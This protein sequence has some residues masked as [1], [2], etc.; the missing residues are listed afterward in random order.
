MG[1]WHTAHRLGAGLCGSLPV[2]MRQET[3]M[4][5]L[6]STLLRRAVQTDR[7][8]NQLKRQAVELVRAARDA[9]ATW[10]DVGVAFGVTRQSAHQRFSSYRRPIT[11]S[12]D[13]LTA[14]RDRFGSE[15]SRRVE[16]FRDC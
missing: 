7:R 16:G 3:T 4:T 6:A 5:P 10:A 12:V 8:A 9:G 2:V 1:F 14:A 11:R 15:G 13:R